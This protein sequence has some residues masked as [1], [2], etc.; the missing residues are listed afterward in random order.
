MIDR[1]TMG[2]KVSKV[3]ADLNKDINHPDLTD[4]HSTLCPNIE[5]TFPSIHRMFTKIEY[6]LKK[7]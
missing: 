2:G 7:F 5:E 3:T 1:T 6:I 4:I